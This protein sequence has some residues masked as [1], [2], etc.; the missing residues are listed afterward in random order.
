M[1]NL[2]S[3]NWIK[4]KLMTVLED[5]T[6]VSYWE[7]LLT[8]LKLVIVNFNYNISVLPDMYLQWNLWHF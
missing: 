7:Y 4:E 6:Y 5:S 8:L 1:G 3:Y 2:Q